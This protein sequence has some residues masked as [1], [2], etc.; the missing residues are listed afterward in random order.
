MTESIQA[1]EPDTGGGRILDL[2]ALAP[3]R[4]AVDIEDQKYEVKVPDDLSALEMADL[5]KAWGRVL[6]LSRQIAEDGQ[7]ADLKDKIAKARRALIRIVMWT[8]IEPSTLERLSL[9]Q[10]EQMT[11]FFIPRLA[12]RVTER[13]AR[14]NAALG[15]TT[16]IG[17]KPPQPSNGSTGPA[18]RQS[19]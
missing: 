18:T 8:P 17:G 6:E 11:D 3:D 12:E 2:G 13:S 9:S 5:Q 4:D 19:G 14:L 16:L 1:R 15:P 7:T 10:L